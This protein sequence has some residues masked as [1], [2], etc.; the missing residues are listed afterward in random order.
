MLKGKKN[1]EKDPGP[2]PPWSLSGENL[3]EVEAGVLVIGAA[4]PF[5]H[6]GALG[7]LN[8]SLDL[9]LERL[10][11]NFQGERGERILINTYGRWKAKWVLI[12][13]LGELESLTPQILREELEGVA[14]DLERLR[15]G[16]RVFL[17]PG[18]DPYKWGTPEEAA[19]LLLETFPGGIIVHPNP[20]V[21]ARLQRVLEESISTPEP[22]YPSMEERETLPR[23]GKGPET[24]GIAGERETPLPEGSPPEEIPPGEEVF[25]TPPME[26][27]PP[28]APSPEPPSLQPVESQLT[29]PLGEEPRKEPPEAPVSPRK[30]PPREGT[31]TLPLLKSRPQKTSRTLPISPWSALRFGI[32]DRYIA[33]EVL[34]SFIMGVAIFILLLFLGRL[35]D[36]LG[37]LRGG[38]PLLIFNIIL[39]ITLATLSMA[40]PPAFFFGTIMATSRFSSDSELIAMESLG[41]SLKRIFVP[42][43]VLAS[44]TTLAT[45]ILALYIT[46]LANQALQ[47]TVFRMVTS[48]P[49]MGI[50]EGEFTRISRGMWVYCS[51]TRGKTLEGIFLYDE[52][53]GMIRFVTAQKGA[54]K[55]APEQMGIALL[56]KDGE[57]LSVKGKDYHLLTFN[58]YGF[59]LSQLGSSFKGGTKKELTLPQLLKRLR[60][61]KKRG[62][63]RYLS[64]LNHFYKRF[65]L[66]FSTLV[67]AILALSLGTFLPRAEK[68]T[69]ILAAFGIFLLYYVLLTLSQ[70]LA[71]KGILPPFLG[72]WAPDILL[73]AG[74]GA[75]LWMKSEKVGL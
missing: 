24:T 65:S 20:R 35:A 16:K 4:K 61:D 18:Y 19:R 63:S 29:L 22:Y 41:L 67:F 62:K 9:I 12:F 75:L 7:Y 37:F 31:E 45:I 14:R 11:K 32:L 50:K 23:D 52:K 57:I 66:P 54:L 25:L 58:R 28:R 8:I 40:I 59:L 74:G 42:I 71:M 34:S 48:N 38:S 30:A 33:G 73:G 44:I 49:K 27:L 17:L 15:L 47:G 51:H 10:G 13:G 53:K 3:R 60:E 39:A 56:L 1:R 70:N 26:E 68:W 72:A 5:R 55:A 69:G 21:L 64:T 36:L 46:P 6:Q 43:G 2:P